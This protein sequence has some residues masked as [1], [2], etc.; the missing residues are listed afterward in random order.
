MLQSTTSQQLGGSA[1]ASQNGVTQPTQSQST[2]LPTADMQ[3]DDDNK[4]ATISIEPEN[5]KW[6][7]T[8][9]SL[10]T[11]MSVLPYSIWS[12]DCFYLSLGFIL[13]Y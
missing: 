12:R 6:I 10:L 7:L 3:S 11:A 13:V 8:C 4:K 1:Q 9:I 2:T 5:A